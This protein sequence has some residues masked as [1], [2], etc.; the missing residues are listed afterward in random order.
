[1]IGHAAQPLHHVCPNAGMGFQV[2]VE[3][4]P[5]SRSSGSGIG[6]RS[7]VVPSLSGTVEGVQQ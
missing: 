3:E 4:S 7:P 1:M 2:V 6:R 5:G